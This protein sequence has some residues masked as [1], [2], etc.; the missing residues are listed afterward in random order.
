VQLV[1]L[2]GWTVYLVQKS[3]YLLSIPIIQ[4]VGNIIIL[5]CRWDGQINRYHEFEEADD[6]WKDALMEF[7]SVRDMI[8]SYRKDHTLSTTFVEKHKISNGKGFLLTKFQTETKMYLKY[9]SACVI[10]GGYLY[11]GNL[12]ISG[13]Y[14]SSNFML[15][16]GTIFQFDNT[17][18]K[19]CTS[20]FSIVNGAV[21]ITKLSKLLNG[22][23]RRKDRFQSEKQTKQFMN[24]LLKKNGGSMAVDDTAI[25]WVNVSY[26]QEEAKEQEHQHLDGASVFSAFAPTVVIPTVGPMSLS[27]PQGTINAICGETRGKRTMMLLLAKFILPTSGYMQV[28]GNLRV[29]YVPEEPLLLS[30]TVVENL[31]FGNRKEH[32]TEELLMVAGICGLS[33]RLIREPE[34]QVGYNGEKLSRTEKVSVC[35]ARALLSSADLILLGKQLDLLPLKRSMAIVKVLRTWVDDRGLRLLSQEHEGTLALKKMKTAF[36]V[37]NTER[38]IDELFDTKI[39]L[40]EFKPSQVVQ[41]GHS[42]H[43]AS[44]QQPG[45]GVVQLQQQQQQPQQEEAQQLNAAIIERIEQTLFGTMSTAGMLS[46]LGSCEEGVFGGV[47]TGSLQARIDTLQIAVPD[48]VTQ[49]VEGIE[50]ALF[51]AI[52]T[53]GLLSRLSNCEE[54]VF[55]GVGTGP[56]QSRIN[57]LENK[58]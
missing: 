17:L 28:P 13:H 55:G 3:I 14:G 53:G 27:V 18:G 9:W 25:A 39:F 1:L 22:N 56:L 48:H 29:R 52:H 23:T 42:E 44:M 12:V 57:N 4:L 8:T 35:I 7:L 15:L 38:G 10:I 21:P 47:G 24:S 30:G 34:T 6:V 40:H 51:G 20:I 37:T 2:L 26:H 11:A 58:C 54:G 33:R 31:K 43:P 32:P 46:R 50:L 5:Y 49:R 16:M 41:N 19:V 36:V 45:L